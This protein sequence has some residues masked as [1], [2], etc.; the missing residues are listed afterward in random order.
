M[1]VPPVSSATSA[2]QANVL[3]TPKGGTAPDGDPAAIEAAENEAL[4]A[5]TSA[6]F[7]G[8]TET[9]VMEFDT[10][11]TP[12]EDLVEVDTDEDPA[13]APESAVDWTPSDE[14]DVEDSPGE[15]D[16]NDTTE[17]TK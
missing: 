10:V 13:A 12:V 8:S 5:E 3:T 2:P 14:G 6:Q 9:D 15:N 16:S 1:S 7:D 4:E 17:E 11:D